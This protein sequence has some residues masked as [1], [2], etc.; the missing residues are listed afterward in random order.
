MRRSK[1]NSLAA[2]LVIA[3]LAVWSSPALAKDMPPSPMEDPG[4]L[5][6][7]RAD[8]GTVL[9]FEVTGAQGGS[10]WGSD[11][12]TDDSN[13]A[14]AAVHAGVLDVGE[15]GIVSVE[16]LGPQETFAASQRNGVSSGSYG[17]W[18]GSYAFVNDYELE[19]SDAP[20]NLT[21]YR[22]AVG[23]QLQFV[24]TGDADAGPV[25]GTGTYTD[26]S[27]LAAAAVHAGVLED[28]ETSVVVVEVLPGAVSYD[29]SDANGVSSGPYG[30]WTGSYRFIKI[31]DKSAAG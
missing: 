27:S 8:V 7:Y 1:V 29:A 5:V 19:V 15:T 6:E 2:G 23:E 3:A 14:A 30:N 12:Y 31:K 4:N 17:K 10:V 11:I 13:L 18:E 24:L 16:I 28:G 25:W 9:T 22:G 21:G 26:D 20:A